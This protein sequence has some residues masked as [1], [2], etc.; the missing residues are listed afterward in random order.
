MEVAAVLGV[1]SILSSVYYMYYSGDAENVVAP[2]SVE[3]TTVAPSMTT[4]MTTPIMGDLM[5][6][7]RQSSL[8]IMNKSK[9]D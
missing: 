8:F 9:L 2:E 4:S 5:N 7:L 6:D 1:S 3:H